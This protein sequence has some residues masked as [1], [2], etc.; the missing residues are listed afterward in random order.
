[1]VNTEELLP[2]TLQTIAQHFSAY[3]AALPLLV[4]RINVVKNEIIFLNTYHIPG[5]G[6]DTFLLLKNPEFA[7]KTILRDDYS[8][9]ETFQ[10]KIQDRQPAS[11]LFRIENQN[12]M[13]LW[14]HAASIPDPA[15]SSCCV[16]T[17]MECTTQAAQALA[18]DIPTHNLE[19]RVELFSHPVLLCRFRDKQVAIL[20]SAAQHFFG[21]SKPDRALLADL[22]SDQD[23]RHMDSVYESLIFSER[24]SGQLFFTNA[25]QERTPCD[26]SIRS[27]SSGGENYL[28]VAF[29]PPTTP[30]LPTPDRLPEATPEA[31]R[32]IATSTKI[33]DLLAALL[34][35]QPKGSPVES[36]M[37]S[38][39]FRNDNR[40][41]VTASGA[42]IDCREETYP[43]KGSIA[44]NILTFRLENLLVEDT[45][46]SIKPIDWALFIPKKIRSYFAK[47]FFMGDNLLYV[48]IFCATEPR[49]F[50]EKNIAMFDQFF[51]SV[52]Q[53]MRTCL[54][55]ED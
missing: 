1:M 51:S 28:W 9:F 2:S 39:V 7:R 55:A 16:G 41:L 27:L 3:L 46:R 30:C 52:D 54:H 5:L 13:L 50:S 31:L 15:M 11:T 17:M 21:I 29:S 34:R 53:G 45:S 44:D 23:P 26:T 48:L 12:G 6:L 25:H 4:W 8:N 14:I 38:R 43:F 20:N 33:P 35:A 36:V 19:S 49:R 24:W 37:L 40:V 42:E 22:L 10:K 32:E 18:M 47:P